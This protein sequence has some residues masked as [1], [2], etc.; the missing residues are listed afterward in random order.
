MCLNLSQHIFVGDAIR[1]CDC[2]RC[3]ERYD[4]ALSDRVRQLPVLLYMTKK[5]FREALGD[6]IGRLST[7]LY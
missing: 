7:L 1:F 6:G 3:P 5:R 2:P 4:S